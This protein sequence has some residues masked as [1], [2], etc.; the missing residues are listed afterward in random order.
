MTDNY[1]PLK[2]ASKSEADALLFT[3]ISDGFEGMVE[4]PIYNNTD[5][6]GIIPNAIGWH[7]NIAVTDTVPETLLPFII[8]FPMYP[9]RVFFTN[10]QGVM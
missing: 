8:P 5:V 1:W 6:I 4:V 3:P 9:K 10:T 7:V 2:F